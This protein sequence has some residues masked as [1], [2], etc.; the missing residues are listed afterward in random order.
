MLKYCH[1]VNVL[2][3]STDRSIAIAAGRTDPN[4]SNRNATRN[5]KSV[6]KPEGSRLISILTYRTAVCGCS[7]SEM[8]MVCRNK[9]AR[10][11][12]TIG[13]Y[14]AKVAVA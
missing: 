12:K 14:S 13:I 3:P 11:M 5:L 8:Q 1:G 9:Q 10:G 7:S 6:A 4:L 2:P